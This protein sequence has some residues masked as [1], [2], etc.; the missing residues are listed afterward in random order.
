MTEKTRLLTL[1]LV[2]ANRVGHELGQTCAV[3]FYGASFITDH[4]GAL[5]AEA[6]RWGEGV[7]TAT[8]D[9]EACARHRRAWSVFRDRRP[10][11]Y[12]PLIG[13]DATAP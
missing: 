9:L 6:D 12:G 1:P 4:I 11:L 7:L 5:L 13:L 10:H 3:T 2:A 8:V